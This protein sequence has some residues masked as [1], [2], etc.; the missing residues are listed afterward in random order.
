ME[1]FDELDAGRRG[2]LTRPDFVRA[3]SDAGLA[4]G[5]LETIFDEIDV[6]RDGVIS[7]NDFVSGKFGA[8]GS[9]ESIKEEKEKKKTVGF[10]DSKEIQL[11][12]EEILTLP[13]IA[14]RLGLYEAD[15]YVKR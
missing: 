5:D 4:T 7:R 15:P 1:I 9:I 3:C 2:F 14:Q 6:D 13:D 10:C 11:P 12:T 8:G